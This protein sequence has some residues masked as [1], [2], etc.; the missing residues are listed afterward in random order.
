M[1]FLDIH[2]D[3]HS[4]CLIYQVCPDYTDHIGKKKKKKG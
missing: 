2:Y 1:S 3:F 4:T